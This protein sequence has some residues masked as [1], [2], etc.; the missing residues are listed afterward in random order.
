MK[1]AP[2][3]DCMQEEN[4]MEHSYYLLHIYVL[5]GLKLNVIGLRL[6]GHTT[7]HVFGYSH[8]V[9]QRNI[10]RWTGRVIY[11]VLYFRVGNYQR[12]PCQTSELAPILS[13]PLQ[14]RLL[15]KAEN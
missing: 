13:T 5:L 7:S 8:F 14:G 15:S 1:N 11:M 12:T 2:C 9:L 4:I 6:L 3:H 10:S